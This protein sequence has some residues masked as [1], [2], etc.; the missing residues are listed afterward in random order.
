MKHNFP[1]PRKTVISAVLISLILTGCAEINS[2]LQQVQTEL[3]SAFNSTSQALTSGVSGLFGGTALGATSDTSGN[4]PTAAQAKSLASALRYNGSIAILKQAFDEAKPA[5]Q[6]GLTYLS[7]H[8][9]DTGGF[10]LN[11]VGYTPWTAYHTNFNRYNRDIA[12]N[13]GDDNKIGGPLYDDGT[14]KYIFHP[15]DKCLTVTKVD[16]CKLGFGDTEDAKYASEF[17]CVVH[18]KSD[19]SN[20]KKAQKDAIISMTKRNGKWFVL[21]HNRGRYA[22]LFEREQMEKRY[23]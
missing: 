15:K 7:C 5:M 22:D 6:K 11:S 8:P 2:S 9:Y 19:Y 17:Y 10:H 23:R 1:P 4:Q 14:D 21:S 20:H 13:G 12:A 16:R 3:N 18:Y